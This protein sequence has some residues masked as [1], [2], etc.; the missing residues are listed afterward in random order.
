MMKRNFERVHTP[1][2][3]AEVLSLLTGEERR[4]GTGWI[5]DGT[6]GAGGHSRAL[7]EALP[8]A[9]LL[10]LDQDPDAIEVAREELAEFGDR[11]RIVQ[12]RVSQLERIIEREEIRGIDALLL[13]LGANSLHFDRPER[14]FSFQADGPL[15]MRMDPERT[16]TAADIVNRW[17]EQD[18]ADLFFYEGDERRSRQIARAI[19]AAR[20]R[21]PFLRTIALADLIAQASG[22]RGGKIHPATRCF[23]ALRRAVNEEGEELIAGLAIAERILDADGR[24]AVISFHSGEDRIV[25]RFF[26]E[27]AREGYWQLVTKKPLG[28]V[29]TERRINPRARSARLRCAERR[30]ALSEQLQA[31]RGEEE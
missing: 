20:R 16:R 12:G 3:L 4:E 7:L 9:R 5:I 26:T 27:R 11:V 1:V 13:D 21:V 8:H 2:L 18:L 24:L 28:P 30:R 31:G 23:Q 10:G 17:D 29:V 25:K 19:V 6:L 14:G 22:S 15:D